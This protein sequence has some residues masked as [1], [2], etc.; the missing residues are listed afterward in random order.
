MVPVECVVRGYIT[1]SGWKDYQALGRGLRDRAARRPERVASSCPSRSSRRPPRPSV[2]DHDENVDFD[3]AAEIVGDRGLLEELRRLSIGIYAHGAAHARERGIILADTKFEFGRRADGDDRARRRGA[4]PRLVALLAGRR[5][6]SRAAASRAS[7]SSSCA[8]GRPARAGTS[9]RRRRRCPTEVVEGTR[10][11]YRE[12]Y[13]RITGEP[14]GAWLERTRRD[15]ARAVLIR[16]KEGILDPQGQ[17]VERA[18]PALGFEGVSDVQRRP[19]GRARGR[20]PGA[21]AGDVRAAARQ[22]ADR[23]LR[24]GSAGGRGR[25]RFGVVRFPGCCDEVDAL[26]PAGASRDAELLWHGDRDLRRRRRR[27]RPRRLL[28]R[29]LPARGRDRALLAGDGGGGRVRARRRAGARHLQRLPGALRGRPAARRAA[30]QRRRCASSA[31]RWR[32]R[33]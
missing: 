27:G 13:E 31:G 26:R 21:R 20:G 1:G 8:T 3:R 2:G 10:A 6:T 22:P 19:P 25:V 5:A 33:W 29:R 30:A 12:A 24:G 11:R 23:G 4:H 28:L 18:L 17:A 16:P 9:R 15:D 7:T 14:F 32:S